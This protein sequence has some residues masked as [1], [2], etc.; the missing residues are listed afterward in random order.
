MPTR[1]PRDGAKDVWCST[2]INS[3][4]TRRNDP[5]MIQKDP[6]PVHPTLARTLC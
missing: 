2:E 4:G 6:Y 1:V 5:S 3:Q